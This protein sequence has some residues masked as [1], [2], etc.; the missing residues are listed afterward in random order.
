M[1]SGTLIFFAP[2]PR[3][4]GFIKPD[5]GGRDVFIHMREVRNYFDPMLLVPG[6]KLYF[7]VVDTDR[8]PK[9]ANVRL[10]PGP[11]KR[12][13]PLVGLIYDLGLK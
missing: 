2:P 8:G 4:F 7:D 3:G 5:D 12:G 11:S 10:S 1:A 9:A 13:D 6:V